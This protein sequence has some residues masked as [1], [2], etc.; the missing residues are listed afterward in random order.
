MAR[1]KTREELESEIKHLDAYRELAMALFRGSGGKRIRT[2]Y[3]PRPIL[4]G[5]W[6][7]WL[8]GVDRAAGGVILDSE[9]HVVGYAC[10]V[11]Q[12]WEATTDPYLRDCASQV[13][14][15]QT[16][17]ARGELKAS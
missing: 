6:S 15:L 4:S 3:G 2:V 13:R 10:D 1:K 9:N 14:R 17:A 16:A 12:R 8:Y 7:F 11:A 5:E